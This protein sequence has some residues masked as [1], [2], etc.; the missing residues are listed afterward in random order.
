[1]EWKLS[2]Y[3]ALTKG[4]RWY[5]LRPRSLAARV[6]WHYCHWRAG[7][8]AERSTREHLRRVQGF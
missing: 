4:G 8:R 6:K 7:R 5:F 3:V 2:D 1:M